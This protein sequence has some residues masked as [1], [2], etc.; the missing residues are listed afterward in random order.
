MVD[1]I[2][3][4]ILTNAEYEKDSSLKAKYGSYEQYLSSQLKTTSIH[5]F[6]MSKLK[7]SSNPADELRAYF[8]KRLEAFNNVSEQ[9]IANYQ[10][11]KP[12]ASKKKAEYT[13]YMTKVDN[14]NGDPTLTQESKLN[15]LKKA[16]SEAE[17]AYDAALSLA[18]YHTHSATQYMA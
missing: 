3:S 4:N 10:A 18:L 12:V 8:S 17:Y 1:A 5:T 13:A 16:S 6:D 15:K 2:N 7:S 14:Q 9:L 11:L